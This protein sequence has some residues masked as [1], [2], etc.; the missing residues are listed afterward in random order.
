MSSQHVLKTK[1]CQEYFFQ[2]K[3]SP[4]C[5]PLAGS[6]VQSAARNPRKGLGKASGAL[7]RGTP[8]TEA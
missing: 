5:F 6:L 2:G 3:L 1:C 7:Q 4:E 8:C